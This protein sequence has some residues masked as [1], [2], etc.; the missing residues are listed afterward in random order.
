[1]A[2]I[3]KSQIKENQ[4][5]QGR[6]WFYVK[7]NA[8]YIGFYYQMSN[9]K[10]FTGKTPNN[11]PNEEITKNTPILS[12]QSTTNII[13]DR[14]QVVEYNDFFDSSLDLKIYG[15]LQETDYNLRRSVPQLIP[16][17][18][19]PEDYEKGSFIR[20]FLC[21]I[22]QL[23]Y[24]EVNKE[25]YDNINTQNKV[26][27]WEDY[28]PFILNWYIKGDID[29]VFNNNKGSIFIADKNIKR[30]GLGNYLEKKYLKYYYYQEDNDLTTN[31][32]ELIFPNGK[33][34]IGSYHIHLTQGPMEGSFHSSTSHLKLFYKRFYISKK[35]NTLNQKGVI[36]TGETQNLEYRSIIHT[37]NS[38]TK[39]GY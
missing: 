39:G 7:N 2:Y 5:T 9:G 4:F 33:D 20:Y 34:Y 14:S 29:R 22:N 10:A 27:M 25:T 6:E 23:E 30:K 32:G 16:T 11:P 17:L 24:L 19:T 8:P 15:I 36:E 3:P 38:S 18:P 26:W 12:Q 28:I 31:G 21:R 37:N 1:M 13:G 35:V